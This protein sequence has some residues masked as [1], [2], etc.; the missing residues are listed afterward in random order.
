MKEL[1][2]LDFEGTTSGFTKKELLIKNGSSTS[3]TSRLAESAT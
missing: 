2:E 3:C 1:E